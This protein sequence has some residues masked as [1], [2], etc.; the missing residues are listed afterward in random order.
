MPKLEKSE[1]SLRNR[2]LVAVGKE[3]AHVYHLTESR[4]S[5]AHRRDFVNICIVLS[6]G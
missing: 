3:G 4:N 2:T 5:M 6:S 1:Q